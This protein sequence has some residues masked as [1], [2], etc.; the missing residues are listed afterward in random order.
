MADSMRAMRRSIFERDI[1]PTFRNRLLPEILPEDLRKLCTKVPLTKG[2][3]E[4]LAKF[5][6]VGAASWAKRLAAY[7]EWRMVI[8]S[9]SSTPHKLRFWQTARR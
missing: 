3:A 6:S 5:A 8:S 2:S 9:K 4:E 7:L 1:L